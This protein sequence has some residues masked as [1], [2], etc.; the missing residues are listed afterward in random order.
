MWFYQKKGFRAFFRIS[1]K[2]WDYSRP[3]SKYMDFIVGAHAEIPITAPWNT[4]K[5][6]KSQY[7][8]NHMGWAPQMLLPSSA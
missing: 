7:L 2:N 6:A 1:R 5:C 3:R 8:E 4:Q